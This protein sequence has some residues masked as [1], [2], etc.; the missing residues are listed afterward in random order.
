MAKRKKSNQADEMYIKANLG[1][2]AHEISNDIDLEESVVIDL[3]IQ[4]NKKT[5]ADNARVKAGGK[6]IGATLTTQMA[7][8]VPPQ[9]DKTVAPH[10]YKTDTGFQINVDN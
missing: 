8:Y 5:F 2:E 6:T 3:L 10:I 1:K 7:E 9:I 4:F